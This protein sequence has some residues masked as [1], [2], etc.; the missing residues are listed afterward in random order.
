MAFVSLVKL[1][2]DYLPILIINQHWSRQGLVPSGNKTLSESMLTQIYVASLKE[3]NSEV[4][5]YQS[6]QKQFASGLIKQ[7]LRYQPNVSDV[8]HDENLVE[9]STT[10]E[11]KYNAQSEGYWKWSQGSEAHNWGCNFAKSDDGYAEDVYLSFS[12]YWIRD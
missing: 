7:K 12:L 6:L 1:P 11:D 4:G 8:C 2:P 3:L 10:V 9:V 5:Y